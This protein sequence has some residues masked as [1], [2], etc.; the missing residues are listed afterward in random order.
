MPEVSINYLAVLVGA[1]VSM[2]IGAVWYSMPVFGKLWMQEIGKKMDDLKGGAK[3]GYI[4]AFVS[5]LVMSYILAHFVDYTGATTVTTGAITGFWIW[6][7]FVAT[8]GAAK[9]VFTGK[10]FKLFAIDYGYH[11]VE[12]VVMGMIL[13]V[14]V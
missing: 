5:A 4:V 2:V 13:A 12:L 14:W 11:L 8:V 3:T 10:S 6:F 9:T 7:G 1:I